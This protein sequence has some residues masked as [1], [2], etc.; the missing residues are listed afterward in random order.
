M[1]T[2]I[3]NV[4]GAIVAALVAT[5]DPTHAADFHVAPTGTPQAAGT[6]ESPWDL[7]T[8]LGPHAAVQ[9]G[10]T[11]WLHPGT[12]HGGFV[13][14]LRGT[15][16]RPIV[17]RGLAGIGCTPQRATIDS[18]PRDDRDN[19]L[20][21][22]LGADT[23]YRDFEVTC[24]DP[25]RKTEIA[26]PWPADV[27]R[28]NIDIRGDRITVANVVAHDL[29][30]GFG[31][32]SEGE[33][34]TISG[35]LVYYNGWQGPDRGHGHAIYA[36]NARGTKRMFDNIVFH[37]F[38]YGIHCYGSE[39]ASLRSFEI[40]GNTAFHNGCLAEDGGAPGIMVGGGCP[41][42]DVRVT[43]NVVVGGGIRLGYPWGVTNEDVVCCDNY[44][45]GLVVRD[46]RRAEVRRNT[47][48]AHSTAVQLEGAAR[49]LLSGLL[50]DE[51]DLHVTDGRWG[52]T[53]VVE[54][55]K[56][57]GL[58]F[59]EW[60]EYTHCDLNSAFAKGRPGELRVIVRP[61]ALEAGRAHVVVLNPRRQEVVEVDLSGV[62]AVGKAFRMVS[63][64]DVFGPA[65]A[66]GTYDG[67]PVRLPMVAV[68]P[69]PPV[70]MP[71]AQVPATEPEF[72]A[73]VVLPVA[74]PALR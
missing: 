62:L 10:D 51:N 23:V 12:Y 42:G 52:D 68:R 73:Y 71:D 63:A 36:Q 18:T 26:G 21:V 31:F 22:L 41:V 55:G 47:I 53:A 59:S 30:G 11:I 44:C 50:W 20:L 17:V 45:E 4:C 46:F 24:S 37:Q 25:H 15:P 72:G 28:G 9:P 7:A 8:A 40:D 38:G 64:K 39:K 13:S 65:L 5:G 43:N 14:E 19:A 69:P 16:Q 2:H 6:A 1:R 48:V 49:L 34:G 56:S 57:R 58:T 61:N 3:Q 35:C 67:L 60:Q 33:S 27:R 29:A 54:D 74:S 32:W 66:A 70:G